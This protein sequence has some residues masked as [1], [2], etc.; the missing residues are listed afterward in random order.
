[1]SFLLSCL[2]DDFQLRRQFLFSR[3]GCFSRGVGCKAISENRKYAVP[4]ERSEK[5]ALVLIRLG[6]GAGVLLGEGIRQVLWRIRW[7]QKVP[8]GAGER[9]G[10]FCSDLSREGRWNVSLSL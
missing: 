7:D 2:Q 8:G 6:E 10:H 5:C 1:M 3:G 9:A 4:A